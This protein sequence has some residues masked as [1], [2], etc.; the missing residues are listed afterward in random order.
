MFEITQG[1]GFKITFS[2]GITVSVQFGYGNFCDNRDNRTMCFGE[3]PEK[4]NSSNAEIAVWDNDGRWIT[5]YFVP[6]LYDD[7]IGYVTP[8][9]VANIIIQAK[10]I[11]P[12]KITI[13]PLSEAFS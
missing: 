5:R 9:E 7:V 12:A 2:N 1:K 8:D 10:N 13:K 11:N 3:I 6:D 4:C